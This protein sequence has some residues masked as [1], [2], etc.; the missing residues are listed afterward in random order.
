MRNGVHGDPDRGVTPVEQVEVDGRIRERAVKRAAQELAAGSV[1]AIPTDTVY[2]LAASLNRPDALERVYEI[3]GRPGDRPLPVLLAS[4]DRLDQ[5][6]F[7]PSAPM[8]AILSR[9]WPGALTVAL[10]ARPGLPSRVLAADG[11]VGVRVPAHQ[12]TVSLLRE[13]GGALAVTSANRS[14]EPPGLDAAEVLASLAPD[15]DLV[16]DAGST[17]GDRA[18]TVVGVDN[19]RLVLH[20]EGAIAWSVLQQAWQLAGGKVVAPSSGRVR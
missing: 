7:L 1:I 18:S 11:T 10:P 9:F 2:G 8:R 13:A 3:K 17:P 5:I 4:V 6:A 20:R 12:V 16:L 19:D 15:I 14:G